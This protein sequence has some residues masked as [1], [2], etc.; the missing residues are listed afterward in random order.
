MRT[1][2]GR[3]NDKLQEE[4]TSG[5]QYGLVNVSEGEVNETRENDT[6]ED[7]IDPVLYERGLGTEERKGSAGSAVRR[8]E[9]E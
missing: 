8:T 9:R 2:N 5:A 7:T 6:D 4:A 3:S 1:A